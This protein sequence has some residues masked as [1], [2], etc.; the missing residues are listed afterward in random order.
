MF[1]DP[2]VN[3]ERAATAT[4]FTVHGPGTNARSTRPPKRADL[5]SVLVAHGPGIKSLVYNCQRLRISL[6]ACLTWKLYS[7]AS[8]FASKPTNRTI[9]RSLIRAS[10]F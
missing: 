9:T 4:P 5:G 3:M 7:R 2:T 8:A 6:D 1:H 10:S